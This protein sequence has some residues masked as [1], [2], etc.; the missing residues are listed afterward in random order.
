MA[1][2]QISTVNTSLVYT[3]EISAIS[4]TFL[5]D[6]RLSHWFLFVFLYKS[7]C[8]DVGS[9]EFFAEIRLEINYLEILKSYDVVARHPAKYAE[10]EDMK[11]IITI[12]LIFTLHHTCLT[13]YH[14]AYAC[15]H[16]V[17]QTLLFLLYSICV[18]WYCSW[19]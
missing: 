1:I 2:F 5:R 14:H 12:S 15:K 6:K 4:L 9:R 8:W 18:G 7:E 17:S 16:I 11:E 3:S 13:D 19:W 10:E